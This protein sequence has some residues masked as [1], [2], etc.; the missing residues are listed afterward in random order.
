MQEEVQV[1]VSE[2]DASA[3]ENKENLVTVKQ[4]VEFYVG[5]CLRPGLKDKDGNSKK[6]KEITYVFIKEQ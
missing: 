3:E 2:E 1:I 5:N 4:N 6:S